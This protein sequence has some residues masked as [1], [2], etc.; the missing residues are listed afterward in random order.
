MGGAQTAAMARPACGNSTNGFA[1]GDGAGDRRRTKGVDW[2]TVGTMA[3]VA[4]EQW[5]SLKLNLEG[6]VC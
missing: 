2:A 4:R 5:R 1:T 6:S 3:K